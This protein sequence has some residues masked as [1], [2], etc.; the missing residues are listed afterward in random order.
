[1]WE[2]HA[3]HCL[4]LSLLAPQVLNARNISSPSPSLSGAARDTFTYFP[5]FPVGEYEGASSQD[6]Y[7]LQMCKSTC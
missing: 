7:D 2:G 6:S 5:N 1:M 4:I 3:T